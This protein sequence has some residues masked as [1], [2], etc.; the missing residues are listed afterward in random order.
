MGCLAHA[1]VSPRPVSDY[2]TAEKPWN[3]YSGARMRNHGLLLL[4]RDGGN[5]P[6]LINPD[7]VVAIGLFDIA[8]ERCDDIWCLLLIS[9]EGLLLRKGQTEDFHRMGWFILEE[10]WWFEGREE[11]E[12]SLT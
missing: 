11:I 9:N 3:L 12:I 10:P 7:H 8:D 4:P 1:A 5:G 6:V 2:L